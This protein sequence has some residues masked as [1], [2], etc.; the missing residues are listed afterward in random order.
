M[1][2]G[3]RIRLNLT[4]LKAEDVLELLYMCKGAISDLEIFNLKDFSTG[5]AGNYREINEL[6][7][8]I[9]EENTVALKSSSWR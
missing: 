5:K 7:R 9:N 4:N 3:C 6:Q 2:A 8:A 1:R